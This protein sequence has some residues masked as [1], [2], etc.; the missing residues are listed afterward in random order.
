MDTIL[1]RPI[2]V[3]KLWPTKDSGDVRQVA[4]SVEKRKREETRFLTNRPCLT[5]LGYGRLVTERFVPF[6][7]PARN[8]GLTASRVSWP[9]SSKSPVGHVR[10]VTHGPKDATRR[11]EVSG[12]V[13]AVSP[14]MAD[15]PRLT[16]R[17]NTRPSGRVCLGVG[18]VSPA[19]G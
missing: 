16:L 14:D 17:V 13:T 8:Q 6:R 11:H 18:H 4:V 7:T 3:N 9:T 10:H 12:A 15:P 5:S 1:C 19:H 2:F